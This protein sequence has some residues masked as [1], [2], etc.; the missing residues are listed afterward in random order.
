[1]SC[2]A[3]SVKFGILTRKHHCRLCGNIFCDD[4]TKERVLVKQFGTTPQRSCAPCFNKHTRRPSGRPSGP[5]SDTLKEI[6]RNWNNEFQGLWERLMVH[7]SSLLEAKPEEV[8]ALVEK[9]KVY[10]EKL[11]DVQLQFHEECVGVCKVIV[12]EFGSSTKTILPESSSSSSGIS[13]VHK[14]IVYKVALDHSNIYGGDEWPMKIALHERKSSYPEYWSTIVEGSPKDRREHHKRIILPPK[15]NHPS[16]FLPLT[17]LVNSR[18]SW[19]VKLITS[20]LEVY[21]WLAE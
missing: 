1:M 5:A 10:V 12:K 16:H 11:G 19:F 20:T 15:S 7:C 21:H 14:G 3:C 9:A 13:Y 17:S 18:L 8:G 2:H 4:C 6:N